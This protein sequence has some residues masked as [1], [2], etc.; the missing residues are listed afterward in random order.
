MLGVAGGG[1]GGIHGVDL[2]S[3]APVNQLEASTN[4]VLHGENV[5]ADETRK[6]RS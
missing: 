1:V 5:L 2:G 3:L 4:S 6:F